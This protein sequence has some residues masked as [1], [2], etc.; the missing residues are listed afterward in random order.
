M[1]DLIQKIN[2]YSLEE[3]MGER[4]AR[5]SKY[6]IQ[7]RAI[8]DVRDGLK[9]VQ[10]RILYSMYK[11]KNTF[12]KAYKKSALTVGDVIGKFH[13][14]GD[15][16]IYEAMVRMS[17][18][19][20]V[21]NPYIDMHGNNGSID[22]D[23]AAAYRYTE[24]RLSKLA[25]ELLKDLEKNT[26]LF[27][28]NFD[29]SLEEPTILPT[30]Y[31]NLLVN[32][33]SGISAG[34]A[35]D[36]PPHNLVEVIDATI[37]RIDNP[38]CRLDTIMEFI[39]GPDFPT[40]G[41]I[42][43]IEGIKEAYETGRG[44][45]VV[46]CKSTFDKIKG[47]E[48][49]I[50]TEIPY[51]VNKS[52]LIKKMDD[53]RIDKK[54]DGILE[55]RDESDK[56]GLRIAIDIKKD[57]NKELIFNYLLKNTDLQISYN[58]N[59]VVIAHRRPKQLGIIPMIDYFIE[60]QKE[61]I[62]N[63]TNF[64]LKHAETRYHIVVGFIKALSILDEIIKTI[65]RSKD[66]SDAIVNLIKE[67]EF[68]EVQADA[69][70]TMQLYRLTNTDVTALEEELL[71]LTKIID[72]LKQ[73]L[74][75][76]E[77]LKDVIKRELKLIKKEYGAPRLSQ[78]ED[79]ITEIKIDTTL[80]ITKEDVVVIVTKD[81]YVK[82][83]SNRSYAASSE[84]DSLVKAGDYIIANY[85]MNTTDTILIFTDLGNYLYI[86]VH[87]LPDLK[88]KELGKHVSNIVSITSEEN[89]IGAIPI[90]DFEEDKCI[91]FFTKYG[92]TKRVKL[93][94]FKA[95]RNSK[96]IVAIKLKEKD[97]VVSI[98][99]SI[100][101]EVFI[102]TNKGYGLWYDIEEIPVIGTKGSGV[103]AINLKDDFVVSSHLFNT[104]SSHLSVITNKG[105]GKRIALEEF[106]KTSRGKRGLLI[107][108]DIKTNPHLIVKT[109]IEDGKTTIGIKNK[110]F[111]TSMR[112]N[113]L[114]IADRYSAGSNIFKGPIDDIFV[115][116]SGPIKE[117]KI[118]DSDIK[119]I[120]T[121]EE[122][123]LKEIDDRILTIDDFLNDFNKQ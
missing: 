99:S 107:I 58:F 9:P 14:H 24:A 92:M 38:N 106:D 60:H 4:F 118:I 28:P 41:I 108:R 23:P 1:K 39:K 75:D 19:W 111:I 82:R 97:R 110:E 90:Y 77:K 88:W 52:V 27:A 10:R 95:Q 7:D 93:I 18:S 100:S 46:K 71:N 114:S 33:S 59:M 5:Y 86:P 101:T 85:N 56:D 32:G 3:I 89:V 44:K 96:P 68:T 36:I 55:V 12:D 116:S 105:T 65:R 50:V 121:K 115:L 53:I 113:T 25:G 47:K 43:G 120:V 26:V 112:L 63:R 64:D 15:S 94:D 17:Q 103:K 2:D 69:I 42:E 35:T 22:G 48:S 13:P 21:K 83:V 81:G 104:Q 80:M 102:S 119:T 49:I 11:N 8:P 51:E 20:K 30:K 73:I 98:H 40:G 31:P 91:T 6:I 117:E 16:S 45:I 70:V 84:E 72:A 37:K 34:Y 29:D 79:E 67:Y 123:S 74:A 78:I 54:I 76:E 87:E 57:A 122:V 109:F 66:K 61:V 62:L